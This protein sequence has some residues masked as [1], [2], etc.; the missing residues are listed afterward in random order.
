MRSAFRG[1]LV[2]AAAASPLLAA[3]PEPPAP[4][5]ADVRVVEGRVEHGQDGSWKGENGS[6]RIAP[7][8]QVRTGKDGLA[9]LTLPW[10]QILIGRDTVMSLPSGRVLSTSL[11]RGRVEQRASSEILKVKTPEAEIRGA[12]V[13]VVSR[14]DEGPGLTRVSPLEGT[15]IVKAGRKV[16]AVA[17]GQGL[18]VRGKGAP[19]EV[20]A[21]PATPRDLSPGRDPIYVVRGEPVTLAWTGTARRYHVEVFDLAGDQVLLSRDV[22]GVSLPISLPG[23]GTF[24]WRVSA[25]DED[26]LEGSPSEPGFVCV[27]EK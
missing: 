11:E 3:R 26:G 19:P 2:V 12:G 8:D 6:F 9:V 10:M 15:F 14:A 24:R 13:V 1:A 21:L 7:G 25:V 22:S 17:P 5:V 18:L 16:V 23:L 27:V 20:V 4:S